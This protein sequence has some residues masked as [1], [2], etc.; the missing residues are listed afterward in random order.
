MRLGLNAAQVMLP[1]DH[2]LIPEA[3][4][5]PALVVVRMPNGATHF[6][7]LWRRHGPL[8]QVMD[9]AMGRR[10]MTAS[11]FLDDLYIHSMGV[12]A[13]AWREWAG[14]PVSVAALLARMKLA[15]IGGRAMLEWSDR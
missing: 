9:P 13:S 6:V 10:W 15:G 11:S 14:S 2:L 7:V 5:L 3:K 4:A 12:D 8:V 1:S